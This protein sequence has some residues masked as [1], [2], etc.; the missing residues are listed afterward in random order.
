MELISLLYGIY[1]RSENLRRSY[2]KWEKGQ[3]NTKEISDKIQEESSI[4][5][6]LV[7][8]AAL[9]YF[10]DP[11]FNWY[12]LLRPIALSVE[13]IRLGSLTRYK[14]TN[15]FYRQPEIDAIGKLREVKGFKELEE[16]PPFPMYHEL[17]NESYLHFL[18]GINSFVRMSK[19]SGD[20]SK[21]RNELKDIYLKLI[22]MLKIKRLLIY[23]PFEAEDFEIYN[24][25]KSVT[26]LFL[27]ITGNTGRFSAEGGK[28]FYSIIGN[29]PYAYSKYCEVPGIKVVDAQSTK[30]DDGVLEK[31]KALSSDFDKLIVANTESFDFLPR[32]I[33]DKKV[34]SFKGGA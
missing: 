28:K 33:A 26:S 22:E 23:E 16:N 7:K 15:T 1:P 32:I 9:N 2:G 31:V 3:L 11:L 17:E 34:F 12:D 25:L 18:P 29:D 13:G 6:E 14:E 19:V 8:E 30:I 20:F 27:V 4:Y 24:E 10:T 5:Y 21:V